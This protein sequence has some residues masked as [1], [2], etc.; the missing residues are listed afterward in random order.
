MDS[1]DDEAAAKELSARL[2]N[3]PL[4]LGMAAAYMRRC[5]V[6]VAEYLERFSDQTLL[7]D[8]VSDYALSV[9]S[10]LSLSLEEVKKRSPVACEVLTLLSFLGPDHITKALIRQLLRAKKFI[11]DEELLKR[12]LNGQRRAACYKLFLLLGASFAG[13]TLAFGKKNRTTVAML[14]ISTLMATMGLAIHSSRT[15]DMKS[16]LRMVSSG[17][18]SSCEYEQSDTGWNILKSFSLL[19]VKDGKGSVHRLLQQSIRSNQDEAEIKRNLTICV[20]ALSSMCLSTQLKHPLGKK[21]C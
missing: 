11:D 1:L 20:N 13:G 14:A 4:A 10:S 16:S 8:K 19:T 21:V 2:G 7:H 18:F 17:T 3:L 6:G 5:D 12:T 9:A 15:A